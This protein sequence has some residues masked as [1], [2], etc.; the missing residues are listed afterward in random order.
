MAVYA[1]KFLE[2]K[3]SRTESKNFK[4]GTKQMAKSHKERYTKPTISD[5]YIKKWVV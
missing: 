3:N 1:E 4:T 2:W 5:M